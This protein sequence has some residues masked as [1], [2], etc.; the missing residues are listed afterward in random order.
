MDNFI[1][2][3]DVLNE[4]KDH[5]NVLFD[6]EKMYNSSKGNSIYTKVDRMI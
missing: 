4:M 3:Y 1:E 6:Y 2:M 5:C